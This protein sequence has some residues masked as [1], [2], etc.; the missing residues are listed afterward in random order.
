MHDPMANEQH[1]YA[2]ARWKA[3]DDCLEAKTCAGF[4]QS[5]W[6]ASFRCAYSGWE[7]SA[8]VLRSGDEIVGG[9]VIFK[10]SVNSRIS[11]YYVPDGPAWLETDSSD[12]Q[13]QVFRAIM[14]FVEKKRR[15]ERQTVSHI[16]IIPRWRSLPSFAIGFQASE[17]FYGVPRD[18]QCIDLTPPEEAIL[19]QMKPKGR[20]NIAVARRHGVTVVEDTSPQGISNFVEIYTE[21]NQRKKREGH[22]PDYFENLISLFSNSARGS[23]FFAEHQGIRLAAAIVVYFGR[24]ATYYY[25]GSRAVHREVMAP[26]ALHFEIMRRS[27]ALGCQ[28]YDLMGVAPRGEP[29]NAWTDIS[30]FKRKFGGQE[31]RFVPALDC[32]YNPAAYEEWRSIER[33]RRQDRRRRRDA[34]QQ[35][36][37]VGA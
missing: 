37:R 27:R 25:G 24:T 19:A 1:A 35:A 11:Y 10:R 4:R 18:T 33:E 17:H 32:V 22:D 26:Y 5:S 14:A 6:Y 29:A 16:G 31:I 9:A 8:T 30:V 7:Q 36:D 34:S 15:S 12:E 28:C 23:V 20:Y 2:P 21:T 13:E 3:W